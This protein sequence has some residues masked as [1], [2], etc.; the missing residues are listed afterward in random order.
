MIK[1]G[2]KVKDKVTGFVGIVTSRTEYLN[3]CVRCSVTPKVK[4]DN[5]IIEA[6]WVDEMQLEVVFGGLDANNEETGGD[7]PDPPKW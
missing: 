6:E 3:G 1:L 5:K 4:K 2:S 7:M